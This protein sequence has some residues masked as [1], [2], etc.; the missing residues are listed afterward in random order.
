MRRIPWA[1]APS[2]R[3]LNNPTCPVDVGAIE[4][5]SV[6]EINVPLSETEEQAGAAP[7]PPPFTK[8]PDVRTA[9]DESTVAEEKYGIPPEVPA[10]LKFNVPVVVTGDPVI[11]KIPEEDPD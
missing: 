5:P 2:D 11:A 10:R 3:I 8:H 7:A 9:E 1:T 6:V 4:T